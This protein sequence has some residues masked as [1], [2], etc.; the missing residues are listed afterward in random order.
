[1]QIA[2]PQVHLRYD[3]VNEVYMIHVV[4]WMDRTKFRADGHETLPSVAS[5]GVYTI[6][7]KIKED[8]SVP[9]MQLLTPVVHTLTLTGVEIGEE[10]PFISI[11]LINSTSSADLGKR[12]THHDDADT[13]GMP[14][15]KMRSTL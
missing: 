8:S 12:K 14:P 5:D 2:K 6:T 1:M 10:D 7:L 9:D 15:P 13:S 4:T 11:N 3:G